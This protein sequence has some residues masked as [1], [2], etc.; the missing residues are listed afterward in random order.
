MRIPGC[1]GDAVFLLIKLTCSSSP[2]PEG[3]LYCNFKPASQFGG[4]FSII[5]YERC[6]AKGSNSVIHLMIALNYIKQAV[7]GMIK[8]LSMWGKERL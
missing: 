8:G 7:E 1:K 6:S 3:L 2:T 5:W 4:Y